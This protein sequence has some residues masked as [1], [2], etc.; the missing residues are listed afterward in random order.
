MTTGRINQVDIIKLRNEIEP[1]ISNC[2]TST[3]PTCC[4]NSQ[5]A[6]AADTL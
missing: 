1:T 5:L 6:D 2:S 4:E 3:A